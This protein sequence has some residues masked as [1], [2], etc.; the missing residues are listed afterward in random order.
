MSDPWSAQ[1]PLPHAVEQ[2]L[3]DI[4]RK[5]KQKPP[6][7]DVRL[8]LASLGEEAALEI[9]RKISASVI[10]STLSAFI[11]YMIKN[12]SPQRLAPVSPL[13]TPSSPSRLMFSPP[14]GNLRGS[15][16]SSLRSESAVRLKLAACITNN[17]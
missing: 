7:A 12:E 16:S 3:E 8:K 6:A 9:L 4:C 13:R 10:K 14:Q 2:L 5:Q 15:P 1:V 17:L 11:V